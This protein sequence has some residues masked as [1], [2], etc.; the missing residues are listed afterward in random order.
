M[1]KNKLSKIFENFDFSDCREITGDELYKI[2]GGK[3][4][5]NSNEGVASAQPGDTIIRDDHTEITL[6]QGDINW[7]QAHCNSDSN[8]QIISKPDNL[9]YVKIQDPDKPK[10]NY[11][12]QLATKESDRY[13]YELSELKNNG[14]TVKLY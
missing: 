1:M 5:E 14:F 10:G 12:P 3:Q 11:L 7:A 6:N 13:C 9:E 4:V 8:G 2:N